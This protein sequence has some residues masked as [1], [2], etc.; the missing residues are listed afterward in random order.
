MSTT[1]LHQLRTMAREL[2]VARRDPPDPQAAAQLRTRIERLNGAAV[3]TP[4]PP[5]GGRVDVYG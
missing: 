3:P 4:Q 2:M 1:R 5:A